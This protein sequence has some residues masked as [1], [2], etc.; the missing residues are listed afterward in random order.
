MAGPFRFGVTRAPA[1]VAPGGVWLNADPP[2]ALADLRGR[3]ALLDFWTTSCVNCHHTLP[4]LDQ[5]TARFGA[6]LQVIG[7]HSP[8]FPTEK[9]PA[10]VT[11]ALARLNIR[12]PVLHD[13]ELA[14]WRQYAVKAWPTLVLI[15][16]DGRLVHAAS[17][18]PREDEWAALISAA[19]G[20][21]VPAPE[22]PPM[23]PAT[24]TARF[25]FPAK[26]RRLPLPLGRAVYALADTGHHQIV[27]LAADGAEVAR[28]GSGIAGPGDG[29]WGGARFNAPQ[30]VCADAGAL[31]V[32]DTGNHL[33]RRVDLGSLTV[34][35]VAGFGRRGP[36]LRDALPGPLA[37]LASPADVATDG[38]RVFIANAGSHQILAYD[39]SFGMIQPI[40]GS[41]AEGLYDG[42]GTGAVLAQPMG[43][44][45]G[46]GGRLAFVD[47]ESSAVRLLDTASGAVSTVA[48][49]G[50][51]D[52][53]DRDGTAA[54]ALL[55]H[56][57]AVAFDG[58]DA[59]MIADTFNGTIRRLDLAAGRLSTVGS[60]CLDDVCLPPGAPRG[61]CP[62]VG[63]GFIVVESDNHRLV[64]LDPSAGGTA[65]FAG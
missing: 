14:L 55:Q 31:W 29:P 37:A 41:G 22:A 44:D 18:E 58:A 11:A 45:C 38:R 26:I 30:G 3:A 46:T 23:A 43:L 24:G 54:E 21:E 16:P 9:N 35:T 64:R 42:A 49:Q 47:A 59:L 39:L 15:A 48:G 65:H 2:P 20:G 6:H 62:A 61:L 7:I 53:G 4:V 40:A 34:T 8:K 51:F 60:T 13:P 5:L 63:G 25:H 27:L 12:H 36:I 56:P 57:E 33:L 10:H 1:L 50:L 32:A 28:I 17:G 52:F 19:L